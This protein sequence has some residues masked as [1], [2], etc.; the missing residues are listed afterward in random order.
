MINRVKEFLPQLRASTF[1][2]RGTAGIRSSLVDGDG[3]FVSDTMVLKDDNSMHILNYNSPGA[4]GALPIGAA[5]VDDLLSRGIIKNE[6]ND[7]QREKKSIWDTQK[8]SNQMKLNEI[9]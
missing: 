1:R 8:I 6:S 5:I 9:E 3:R 7:R 4:T 2:K